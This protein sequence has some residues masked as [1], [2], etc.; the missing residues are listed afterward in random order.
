MLPPTDERPARPSAR[1][2]RADSPPTLRQLIRCPN[3]YRLG[4]PSAHE[5]ASELMTTITNPTHLWHQLP[6]AFAS[7]SKNCLSLACEQGI[8]CLSLVS[9]ASTASRVPVW[10][11]QPHA[12][13]RISVPPAPASPCTAIWL[14]WAWLGPD[15]CIRVLESDLDGQT[16]NSTNQTMLLHTVGSC[17]L[18][19]LNLW[20]LDHDFQSSVVSKYECLTSQA[21]ADNSESVSINFWELEWFSHIMWS[22]GA[23][24]LCFI[25]YHAAHLG[26]MSSG[27]SRFATSR[28]I[29]TFV[30]VHR[31][32]KQK[33]CSGRVLEHCIPLLLHSLLHL[34]WWK[35][36]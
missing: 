12:S 9:K 10:A 13:G 28:C 26:E 21:Y 7:V 34:M 11:R 4:R 36:E 27:L 22:G 5:P 15:I 8:P 19:I 31:P 25:L 14:G 32:G 35:A 17:G 16:H 2:P 29:F 3:C 18:H 23:I 30:N 6:L 33:Q 24:D 20:W 1:C